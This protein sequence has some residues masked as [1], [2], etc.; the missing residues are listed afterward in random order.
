MF[1]TKKAERCSIW[2]TWRYRGT[3]MVV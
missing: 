2:N 1:H 3:A